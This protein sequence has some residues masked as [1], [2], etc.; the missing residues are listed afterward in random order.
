VEL[1]RRKGDLAKIALSEEG[2]FA[3][4]DIDDVDFL[5]GSGSEQK[6]AA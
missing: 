2:N 6:L 5:F 1:Q 3:G 4:V